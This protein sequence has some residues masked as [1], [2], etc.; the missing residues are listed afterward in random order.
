MTVVHSKCF[1]SRASDLSK[2]VKPGAIFGD[3]EWVKIDDPELAHTPMTDNSLGVYIQGRKKG[4]TNFNRLE[5][6]WYYGGSMFFDSTSGGNARA[7]QIWELNLAENT[8][9][10]VFESPS[11][12]VLN[13]PDN[14]AVSARGGIII[15]ED[16]GITT[17]QTP[18]GLKRYFPR[19]HALSPEGEIHLFA[20]NNAVIEKMGDFRVLNGQGLT[21]ARTGNGCLLTFKLPDLPL[22]LLGHGKKAVCK[23]VF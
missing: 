23:A 6:I 22:P 21:S 5:G 4:G 7:G 9:R 13:M 10:L 17:V 18:K 15:C 3:L 14:L 1:A 16:C 19:L 8:L 20:E 11:K 2:D 12:Q